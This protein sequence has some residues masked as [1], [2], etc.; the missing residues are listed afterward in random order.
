MWNVECGMWNVECESP[1]SVYHAQFE[2]LGVIDR[3]RLHSAAWGVG[4]RELWSW[5]L[6]WQPFS[7]SGFLYILRL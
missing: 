1:E 3:R 2:E 4:P 5:E 6:R 7:F